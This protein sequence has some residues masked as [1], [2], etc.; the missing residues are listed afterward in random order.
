MRLLRADVLPTGVVPERGVVLIDT[1]GSASTKKDMPP[2]R[3]QG[4]TRH[5]RGGAKVTGD[6]E[7]YSLSQPV[8]VKIGEEFCKA[9]QPIGKSFNQSKN[10]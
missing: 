5:A 7:R 10:S 4:E 1:P 8:A 6:R 9:R 3:G 2:L